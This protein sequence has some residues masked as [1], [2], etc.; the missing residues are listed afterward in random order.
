M[1]KILLT[2]SLL[3]LPAVAGAQFAN[4]TDYGAIPDDQ[5]LDDKAI[6]AAI[7]ANDHVYLPAGT[8]D[9]S[10]PIE[11]PVDLVF[12]GAGRG[13]TTLKYHGQTVAM[14]T[15]KLPAENLVLE[16][17]A[18]L[19][20]DAGAVGI[21]I[22]KKH[23]VKISRVNVKGTK[24]HRWADAGIMFEGDGTGTFNNEVFQVNIEYAKVGLAALHVANELHLYGGRLRQCPTGLYVKNST[25]VKLY[26]VNFADMSQNHSEYDGVGIH[27]VNGMVFSYGSRFEQMGAAYYNQGEANSITSL[28]DTIAAT[29]VAHAFWGGPCEETGCVE[30]NY[31][32]VVYVPWGNRDLYMEGGADIGRRLALS[33]PDYDSVELLSQR[34]SQ[35]TFVLRNFDTEVDYLKFNRHG[36]SAYLGRNASPISWRTG[37]P[38]G[39]S[40]DLGHIVYNRS[41]AVGG[42]IGWVC[43]QAGSPGLW[44]PFG[45]IE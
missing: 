14:T 3:M 37:P 2:F 42:H 30:D 45:K 10:L 40:Y 34:N 44:R 6:K 4:V 29:S 11:L 1:E 26:A 13:L 24:D 32:R 43:T 27:V 31:R 23:F 41:P 25:G 33:N 7:A 20:A 36:T 15:D 16:D 21:L 17:F 35:E 8:Y 18:L 22:Q 28:A 9:I 39:G 5:E 38:S 12:K 19:N